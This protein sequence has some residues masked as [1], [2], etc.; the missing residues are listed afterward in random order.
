[1]KTS[2]V[3]RSGLVL[4]FCV[5]CLGCGKVAAPSLGGGLDVQVLCS[6]CTIPQD[7]S[8]GY[9]ILLDQGNGKVWAYR[10]IDPRVK[11]IY[12]GTL[13]KLGEP[14]TRVSS[15]GES[16][17]GMPSSPEMLAAQQ[18]SAVGS[19]RTINTSE[20]T[21]AST[22]PNGF[23]GNMASLDGNCSPSTASCAGL[24]DRELASGTKSGY[25]FTYEPGP[26]INGRIDSYSAYADPLGAAGN[27]YYTDQSGVIR[28]NTERRA[29]PHDPPLAG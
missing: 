9:L 24:I 25:R 2:F 10:D 5:G 28:Q 11:P 1:M 8:H 20:V 22:Y 12:L 17:G 13:S 6:S 16:E 23:S 15:L 18:A 19:L 29:G 7:H 14:V 27:H 26:L 3:V 21:Y 4:T